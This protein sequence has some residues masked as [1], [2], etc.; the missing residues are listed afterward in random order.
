MSQPP[1]KS[2]TATPTWALVIIDMNARDEMGERKYGVR[3]QA[4]NGRDHLQDAYEEALDLACY[5]RAEIEK[6]KGDGR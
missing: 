4:D 6:R 5:L 2:G 3:H 1:P